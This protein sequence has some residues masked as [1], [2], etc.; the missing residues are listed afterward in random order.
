MLQLR[1][2]QQLKNIFHAQTIEALQNVRLDSHD[3]HNP[4]QSVAGMPSTQPTCNPPLPHEG[5]L[6][7]DH[8]STSRIA[9]TCHVKNTNA[10]SQQ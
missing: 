5:M 3:T 2:T 10:C 4:S 9:N 6:A 7:M 1:Y 8:A